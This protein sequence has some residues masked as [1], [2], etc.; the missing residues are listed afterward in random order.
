MP[1]I[2]K[3]KESHQVGIFKCSDEF[4]EFGKAKLENAMESYLKFHVVRKGV[5]EKNLQELREQYIINNTL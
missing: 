2:F 1:E 3:E 5:T 4:L